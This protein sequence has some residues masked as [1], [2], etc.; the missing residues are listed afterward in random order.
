M[1][2]IPTPPRWSGFV[3]IAA[4]V[5][6]DDA[7]AM[8]S[9]DEL[10]IRAHL[11]PEKR[12]LEWTAARAAAKQLAI[13]QHLTATPASC[14]VMK[15]DGRPRLVIDGTMSGRNVSISHSAAAGAAAIHV[16]PIGVDLQ[17]I[18]D[19]DPR[20]AKFFIGEA[21]GDV[22]SD[23]A[24]LN[25]LLHLWC[26]KEAAWKASSPEGSTLKSVRL[27]IVRSEAGG[28]LFD[29]E[30]GERRGTVETFVIER[31][32]ILAVA[33]EKKSRGGRAF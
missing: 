2:R 16:D 26:A 7:R 32:Y 22:V 28:G 13:E 3:A 9:D 6:E 1:K 10:A 11:H 15:I 21:E 25:P 33:V 30:T 23:V 24:A 8:F 17:D 20:A 31:R 14:A 18:R 27:Q 19:I 29:Y 5:T 4:E 12:C